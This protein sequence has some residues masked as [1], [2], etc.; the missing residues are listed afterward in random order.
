M[1]GHLLPQML[2]GHLMLLLM[3]TFQALFFLFAAFF[4]TFIDGYLTERCT[5]FLLNWPVVEEHQDSDF[6]HS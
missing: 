4:Y 3:Y 5:Y 2:N 6:L 1:L